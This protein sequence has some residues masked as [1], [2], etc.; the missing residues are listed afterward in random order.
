MADGS[1]GGPT[2]AA[3]QAFQKNQA[4]QA[5][6]VAGPATWKALVTASSCSSAARPPGMSWAPSSAMTSLA[7]SPTSPMKP[8]MNSSLV[9]TRSRSRRFSRSYRSCTR[10]ACCCS[11]SRLIRV[12]RRAARN[13]PETGALSRSYPAPSQACESGTAR[14]PDSSGPLPPSPAS[15]RS[16]CAQL[17]THLL[18]QEVSASASRWGHH[19]AGGP[20]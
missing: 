12:S 9:Q 18:R 10:M 8:S 14:C 17:R 1:F 15:P 3:V 5:D 13:L 2:A 7:R 11:S 4:L 20:A 6:G 16:G 19:R